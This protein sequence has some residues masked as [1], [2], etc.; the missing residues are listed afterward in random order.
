MSDQ[1][2]NT[3]IA[4]ACGWT[5]VAHNTVFSERKIGRGVFG[6]SPFGGEYRLI[7]NYCRD[8]NAMHEAEN[9]LRGI[10]SDLYANILCDLI[11]AGK[12]DT[13]TQKLGA[14]QL[15]WHGVF[16]V[17][18]ATARQRAEAFLRT[19]GKWKEDGK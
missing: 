18:N 10:N 16:S 5:N 9:S 17:T 11:K 12:I 3:A 7:P 13:Y 4:E 6:N 2:I 8:L 19:I 14:P 1:E 15:S